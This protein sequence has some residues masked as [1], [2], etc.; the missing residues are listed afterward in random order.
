[1]PLV[2]ENI[3]HLKYSAIWRGKGCQST[4][5]NNELLIDDMLVETS[6]IYQQ[7]TEQHNEQHTE[8]HTE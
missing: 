7:H 6:K 4:D 1:M 5:G 2:S 8:H 3:D